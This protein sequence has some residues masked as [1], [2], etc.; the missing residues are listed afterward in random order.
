MP[1]AH[2]YGRP[3]L[4]LTPASPA[5]RYVAQLAAI[6]RA[7]REKGGRFGTLDLEARRA[8]LDEALGAA[9]VRGLPRRPAG[10][11][12]VADLM[13]HYFGSS[14]ARAVDLRSRKPRALP[15]ARDGVRRAPVAG[16]GRIVNTGEGGYLDHPADGCR[17]G[18]D[19][20]SS[21]CDSYGR[22]HDHENLFVVG[23]PTLPT[24]G[25]TNGTLTFVALTLR[26]AEAIALGLGGA[27]PVGVQGGWRR[28]ATGP[29]PAAGAR[30][31][32]RRCRYY[33]YV[34]MRKLPY[35]GKLPPTVLPVGSWVGGDELAAQ[36]G[37]LGYPR[38]A[39]LRAPAG[40]N[41]AN[42]LFGALTPGRA[43]TRVVEALPWL[44]LRYPDVDWDWLVAQAKLNDLQNSL[45][46]VVSLARELAEREGDPLS[47][48]FRPRSRVRSAESHERHRLHRGHQAPRAHGIARPGRPQDSVRRRAPALCPPAGPPRHDAGVR[49]RDDRG[50]AERLTL[51]AAAGSAAA[52]WRAQDVRSGD[53][54]QIVSQ[55]SLMDRSDEKKPDR[56]VLRIDIRVHRA[57]PANASSTR[58]WQST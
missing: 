31:L 4:R 44:V 24:A 46:F 13:G 17:M 27:Q 28:P 8:L 15:P 11:H 55:Y 32:P 21:V 2:G 41:P 30:R 58:R 18:T 9:E 35:R 16:H 12:V 3:R 22:T 36:L 49:A 45:G 48:G 20:A 50:S 26:S 29:R 14:E 51:R 56:A 42:V 25:C 1:L 7:A 5:P 34:F 19:P 54:C 43:E 47:R 6:D 53:A 39:H 23:A 40:A 33:K 37:S 52:R 57:S 38:F 10:Q